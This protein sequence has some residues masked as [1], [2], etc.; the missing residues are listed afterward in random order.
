MM[1]VDFT[2]GFSRIKFPQLGVSPRCGSG[3][4]I[5]VAYARLRVADVDGRD[6]RG[7]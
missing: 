6:S 3:N 2:A 1:W 5:F 7:S 4:P